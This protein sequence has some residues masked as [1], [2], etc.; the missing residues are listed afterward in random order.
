MRWVAVRYPGA[1]ATNLVAYEA[2]L[3]RTFE[4]YTVGRPLPTLASPPPPRQRLLSPQLS[5]RP[6]VGRQ[7]A[8]PHWALSV[9]CRRWRQTKRRLRA[10]AQPKQRPRRR[11]RLRAL[12]W[13]L[14]DSRVFPR[15]RPSQ[16]SSWGGRLTNN[17]RDRWER[18]SGL[19]MIDLEAS[20]VGFKLISSQYAI[21]NSLAS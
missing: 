6:Q 17:W 21:V 10:A 4:S 16:G 7:P 15:D 9:R 8:P 18:L 11:Y 3:E 13:Q 19:S 2:A 12:R 14:E 20:S 1:S 5:A